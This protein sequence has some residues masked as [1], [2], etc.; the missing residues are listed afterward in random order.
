MAGYTLTRV[1]AGVYPLFAI[2]GIA[3]VGAGWWLTYLARHQ[4]I[5]WNRK[6]NPQPWQAV[7]QNQTTKLY[8]PN[9]RFDSKWRRT[10]F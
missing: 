7:Q 2:M 4:D 10:E 3:T 9:A 8:D 1:P 6:S 5:V